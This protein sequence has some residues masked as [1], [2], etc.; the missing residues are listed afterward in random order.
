MGEGGLGK[1][2][3]GREGEL[4]GLIGMMLCFGGLPI[5]SVFCSGISDVI[6]DIT[7]TENTHHA[8]MLPRGVC[9]KAT[10]PK[11]YIGDQ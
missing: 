3:V 4:Y 8:D 11:E 1:E 2:T 7:D 10:T 9:T 5:L 6:C